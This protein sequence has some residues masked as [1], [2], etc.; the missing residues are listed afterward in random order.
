MT[1][2]VR[3]TGSLR[4]NRRRAVRRGRQAGQQGGAP[5]LPEL[6]LRELRELWRRLYK[7]RDAPRLS[8]ELLM[9]AVAYRM[10]ELALGGLRAEPQRQLQQ[11]A[12]ELQQ[13]GRVRRGSTL[14]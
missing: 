1:E 6:E 14:S 9:R 7:T 4:S 11:I 2:T 12:Q 8:R 3:C 5:R 13:T 10:Q